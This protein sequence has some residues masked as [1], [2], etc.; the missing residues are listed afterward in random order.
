MLPR[1][2]IRVPLDRDQ[3]DEVAVFYTCELVYYSIFVFGE[4]NG[5]I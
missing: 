3:Q 2:L 4:V 1:D 5:G